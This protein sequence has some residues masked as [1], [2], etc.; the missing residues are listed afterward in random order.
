MQKK[1]D[2]T[3]AEGPFNNHVNNHDVA[4]LHACEMRMQLK[5]IWADLKKG[6]VVPRLP[7]PTDEWATNGEGHFHL[8][9]ELF[10]QVSGWTRFCFPHGN[11]SEPKQGSS[12]LPANAWANDSNKGRFCLRKVDR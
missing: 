7:T 11:Y 12:T 9:S 10:V 2:T 3:T 1:R 8:A 4:Q 6:L 5:Q